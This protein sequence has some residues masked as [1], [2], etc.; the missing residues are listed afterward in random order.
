MTELDLTEII[1][2]VGAK[3]G[4]YELE[5]KVNDD[6]SVEVTKR[7]R[8]GVSNPKDEEQLHRSLEWMIRLTTYIR[9][10]DLLSRWGA[11]KRRLFDA[12]MKDPD[13]DMME[14]REYLD[15]FEEWMNSFSKPKE[16]E[17]SETKPSEVGSAFKEL[18]DGASTKELV[19]LLLGLTHP[20]DKLFQKHVQ[21]ALARRKE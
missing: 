15:E 10:I 7:F 9:H 6:G 8:M 18:V 21:E 2:I 14:L 16:V 1:K 5:W 12:V 4:P 17:F 11:M 19:G 3:L 13:G 20:K